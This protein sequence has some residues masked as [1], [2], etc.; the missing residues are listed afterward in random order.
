MSQLETKGTQAESWVKEFTQEYGILHGTGFSLEKVVPLLADKLQ[1]KLMC[2]RPHIRREF[3]LANEWIDSIISGRRVTEDR[4]EQTKVAYRLMDL[5][6]ATDVMVRIKDNRGVEHLIAID[7]ASNPDSEQAKLDIIRG[8]RDPRDAPGFNRNHN[9]G[10]V[11]Q[12]LGISK[13]IV[14]VINP[15]HPPDREQLLNQI[16][17][18][19]N[20]P[21]KTGSI[22]AWAD[23]EHQQPVSR[24]LTPLDLW[25]KYSQEASTNSDLQR[26]I[27]IAEFVMRDGLAAKLPAILAHDPFTQK[28]RRDQGEQK[29][30]QH[31]QVIVRAVSTKLNTSKQT[32]RSPQKDK[33]KGKE[34]E[35]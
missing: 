2:A 16:F 23:K 25:Q 19:A 12:A 15:D 31:I 22:T 33:G 34:P 18:F 28:I 32:Q 1:Y 4:E 24:A 10:Q 20:Q 3:G 7:V 11:R 8:K 29:A 5:C 13:H 26:Q 21:A 14:L 27:A 35:R 30:R 9:L 6:A 17:A